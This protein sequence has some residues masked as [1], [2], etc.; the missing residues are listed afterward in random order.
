[1]F[2]L[3]RANVQLGSGLP[4]MNNPVGIN[5]DAAFEH[6]PKLLG[7]AGR[8]GE[9]PNTLDDGQEHGA[10]GRTEMIQLYQ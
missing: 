5:A 6:S 2:R 1:M 7:R 10:P 4:L 9:R 8:C 3:E